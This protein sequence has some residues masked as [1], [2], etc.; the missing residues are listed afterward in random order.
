MHLWVNLSK[1][2]H[3]IQGHKQFLFELGHN[4]ELFEMQKNL[5]TD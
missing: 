4:F 3:T 5:K 2:D 1:K